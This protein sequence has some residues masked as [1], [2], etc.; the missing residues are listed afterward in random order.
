MRAVFPVT[1]HLLFF[2]DDKALLSRRK[3]TGYMDGYYSVPAGHLD[4]GET[5]TQAA[6]REAHEETGLSLRPVAIDFACVLHR[7]EGDERIDFF[8]RVRDWQGEP[9]NTEPH[10]CDELRWCEAKALPENIIPYVWQGI[11]N[12][13]DGVAFGEFGWAEK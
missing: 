12:S 2:R 8:V 3:A 13:L 7:H 9:V 5:V 4:G 10:K 11:L 6:I 1:V